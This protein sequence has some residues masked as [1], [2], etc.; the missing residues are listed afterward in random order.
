MIEPRIILKAGI[1]ER[2]F[3][4]VQKDILKQCRDNNPVM[5]TLKVHFHVHF[6]TND[7]RGKRMLYRKMGND[8]I[9]NRSKDGV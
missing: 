2:L 7:L 1:L 3:K 4:D 9:K 8:L 5:K 6:G